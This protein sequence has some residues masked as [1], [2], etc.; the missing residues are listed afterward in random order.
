MQ[1]QR[2]RRRFIR[3]NDTTRRQGC[4]VSY[5]GDYL[6]VLVRACTACFKR[7]FARNE[8]SD[9]LRVNS[10]VENCRFDLASRFFVGFVERTKIIP[11]RRFFI[12]F[13]FLSFFSGA[14][15]AW[16][17]QSIYRE[18]ENMKSV[19]LITLEG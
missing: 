7:S 1:R 5:V 8:I 12:A 11:T 2:A 16:T 18:R 3:G 15:Q 13:F 4:P 17:M 6:R 19:M 9:T 10:R 14:I